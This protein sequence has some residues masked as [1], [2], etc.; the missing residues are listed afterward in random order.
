MGVYE[1]MGVDP[2][3][4]LVRKG[5]GPTKVGRMYLKL[6]GAQIEKFMKSKEIQAE[7]RRR[8]LAIQKACPTDRGEEWKVA[9]STGRDR[10]QAVIATG[11]E[12]A[13]RAEAKQRALTTAIN[14]GR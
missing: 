6:N 4:K 2:G 1:S 10:A 12:P 5:I 9:V 7:L 13:R 3:A 8:A 11:N 14:A